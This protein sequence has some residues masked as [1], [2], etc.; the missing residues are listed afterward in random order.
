M[1]P[2]TIETL[3]SSDRGFLF[4]VCAVSGIGL[5]STYGYAAANTWPV[6]RHLGL[7]NELIKNL[8]GN[9]AVTTR[10]LCVGHSLGA[11][12]CGFMGK[13]TRDNTNG[14]SSVDRIIGM[15]PAGN[16]I[17]QTYFF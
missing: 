15:D 17:I 9:T 5:G 4:D 1:L 3:S 11:H 10:T 12:V 16:Y 6:G 7:L 14:P 13:T 2:H 8:Q